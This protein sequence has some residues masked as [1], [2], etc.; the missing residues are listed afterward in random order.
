M[1]IDIA[2]DE[3]FLQLV[4]FLFSFDFEYKD[5]VW[6]QMEN[7]AIK[8]EKHEYLI[9]FQFHLNKKVCEL[10]PSFNGMPV[11]IEVHHGG[12]ITMCE[13]FVSQGVLVEYRIYNLNCTKLDMESF[14]KGTA[15]F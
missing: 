14:Q 11:I 6:N 15:I 9:L 4:K 10:P 2:K 13:L 12:D 7:A 3:D 5:I 1:P 8:K